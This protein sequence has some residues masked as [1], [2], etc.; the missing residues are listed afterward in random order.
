MKSLSPE[1]AGLLD[2]PETPELGPGPR[3]GRRAINQ[4]EREVEAALRASEPENK[5]LA[6]A[7]VLLWHDHLHAS[8]EIAQKHETQDGSYVHAIMHRREPDYGNAKY[9]FRRVGRHACYADLA[10]EIANRDGEE[11]GKRLAPG[12]EWD[13]MAFVDACEAVANRNLKTAVSET[14]REIQAMELRILLTHLSR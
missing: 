1:L 10:K 4:I 6:L 3:G 13:A 2:T 8:H 7:V 11:L 12:G 14:L 9:W 5:E